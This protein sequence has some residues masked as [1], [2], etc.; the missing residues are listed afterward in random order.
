MERKPGLAKAQRGGNRKS[1]NPDNWG[2]E[3]LDCPPPL[4]RT[5]GVILCT[6]AEVGVLENTP[7]STW[8]PHLA[9]P[10]GISGKVI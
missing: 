7:F 10:S 1:P 4:R 2:Q 8:D 9:S 6:V 3:E 5:I